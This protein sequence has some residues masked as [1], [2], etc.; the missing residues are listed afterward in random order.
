MVLAHDD[1]HVFQGGISVAPVSSWIY[2]DT[3]YTERYMG[4]PSGNIGGYNVSDLNR[5]AEKMEGREYMLIHG[6][7]D[8]NV[9]YQQAMA[10]SKALIQKGIIFEQLVILYKNNLKKFR[11]TTRVIF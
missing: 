6:N 10:W 4:V 5:Y 7:A 11:F 1:D 2:Y 8:D 9:H 3:I